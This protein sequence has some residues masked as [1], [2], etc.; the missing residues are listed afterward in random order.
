MI[1]PHRAAGESTLHFPREIGIVRG[2]DGSS[3]IAASRFEREGRPGQDGERMQRIAENIGGDLR[4]PLE[5]VVLDALRSRQ[6]IHRRFQ[7]RL[8]V[9]KHVPVVMARHD[10]EYRV[11]ESRGLLERVGRVNL[12]IE[13]Q[14]GEVRRIAAA[15]LDSFRDLRIMRPQQYVVAASRCD[16]RHRSPERSRPDD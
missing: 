6:H 12:L 8:E 5:R 14:P 7:V 11:A 4:H 9:V 13:R 2:D 16:H 10:H 1:E 15:L 3:R